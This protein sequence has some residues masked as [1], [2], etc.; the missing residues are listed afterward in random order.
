MM[1]FLPVDTHLLAC[2]LAC[3]FP[4]SPSTVVTLDFVA[5]LYHIC[6][7]KELLGTPFR[8]SYLRSRHSTD[9]L[10]LYQIGFLKFLDNFWHSWHRIFHKSWTSQACG[11]NE[12]CCYQSGSFLHWRPGGLAEAQFGIQTMSEVDTC[13]WYVCVALDAKAS[14]GATWAVRKVKVGK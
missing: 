14:S 6:W 9:F 5:R 7:S 4:S 10:H 13:S 8:R 1:C 11:L 2:Y 3:H 12:Y